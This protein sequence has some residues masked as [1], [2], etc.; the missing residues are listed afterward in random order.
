MI[1]LWP[2]S[3]FA[4]LVI[5]LVAGLLTAQIISIF[6]FW[7]DRGQML[8]RLGGA[9]ISHR[10]VEI[11]EQLDGLPAPARERLL[12]GI[13]SPRLYVWLL[14]GYAPAR[15]DGAT[16]SHAAE[17]ISTILHRH[18]GD[19]RTL[20]VTAVDVAMRDHH[21][22]V[23]HHPPPPWLV[24]QGEPLV[25]FDV[26][27]AL[28]DGTAAAFAFHLPRA[29]L[30]WPLRLVISVAT[31]IIAVIILA[32][33][34]VRQ[35]TRPLTMLATA[36]DQLGHNI[37]RPPLPE[38]GPREARRAARAFNEMQRQIQQFIKDRTELLAAVSHDLKTPITRLRIRSELLA[39]PAL[40]S[41][42]DAD[43]KEMEIMVDETLAFM[44]G[45]DASEPRQNIDVVALAESL[46]AD[47]QDRGARVTVDAA[48]VTPYFGQPVALKRCL[49]NLVDNALKYADSAHI[50]LRD[51]PG[52]LIVTVDDD[53]PGIPD[54]D[55]DKVFAPFYRV[56]KSRSRDTGGIGM[57]LAIAR[58]VAR[59]HGGDILLA[60]RPEGGLRVTLTLPRRS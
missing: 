6:I 31:L 55:L 52:K 18:L 36:A 51:A 29:A 33:I 57:G 39:D 7:R 3:L 11:V 46:Q 54:S 37:D 45:M 1:R 15:T 44:R 24:R 50:S 16:R 12:R 58:N 32:L 53:G 21:A 48:P 47:A 2:Q 8:Y 40:Q 13:N 30:N 43:L 23:R 17:I 26:R 42:F 5:I 41:K 34:A 59:S 19:S 38:T 22:G 49:G 9:D 10:I 35:T 56:E 28:R 25:A 14:P 27:I 20:S 4:R 60:N